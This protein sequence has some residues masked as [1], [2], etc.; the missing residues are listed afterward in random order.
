MWADLPQ[1]NL[2]DWLIDWLL[3]DVQ[4]SAAATA[5]DVAHK[6]TASL[7][8]ICESMKQQ[9]LILVEWAKYIPSFCELPLDDQVVSP[10]AC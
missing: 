1:I 3:V 8:D 5:A 9:L 7:D 4:I 6:K 2:I 10:L